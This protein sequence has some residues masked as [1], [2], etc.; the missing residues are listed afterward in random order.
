LT[1]WFETGW[2]AV[3]LY[4]GLRVTETVIAKTGG[5]KVVD[6]LGFRV[7][8]GLMRERVKYSRLVVE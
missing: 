5:R 4:R 7:S 1:V 3:Y 8:V 2:R 6:H